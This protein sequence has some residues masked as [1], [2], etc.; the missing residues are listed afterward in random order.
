MSIS[1]CQKNL[2]VFT[3]YTTV[4]IED[5]L[6]EEDMN[7]NGSDIELEEFR[8]TRKYLPVDIMPVA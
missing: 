6:S 3:T 2:H 7:G 4:V 5:N 8:A 1:L